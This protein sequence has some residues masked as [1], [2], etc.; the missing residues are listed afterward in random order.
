MRMKWYWVVLLA[1][2]FI[3]FTTQ[4][5]TPP[6]PTK[7]YFEIVMERLVMA[8]SQGY[9]WALS[10]K[11]AIGKC[12]IMPIGL[13]EYNY[14]YKTN[15][16][17]NQLWDGDINMMVGRGILSNLLDR[18][19]GDYCK[20]INS[21]NMGMGR[22]DNNLWYDSYLE[23]IVPIKWYIMKSKHGVFGRKNKILYLRKHYEMRIGDKYTV[24]S[25]P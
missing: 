15:I 16:T 13:K 14:I 8:E 24:S 18:L 4:E 5:P 6:K 17:T 19:D 2:V 11:G 21:Y 22:T 12:Q 20:A 3:S 1:P 23:S 7:P 9:S 10:K 25:V